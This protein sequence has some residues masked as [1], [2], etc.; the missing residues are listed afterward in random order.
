MDMDARPNDM[1]CNELVEL[2][3]DYLEGALPVRERNRFE[4]HIAK[5]EWC[6]RYI[7]QIRATI[8]IAGRLNED[9]IPQKAKEE[10]LNVFRDWKK[11][12]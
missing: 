12:S 10:L 6:K 3:T 8:K 4:L 9:S 7:D 5:C 11:G 1:S 2:V